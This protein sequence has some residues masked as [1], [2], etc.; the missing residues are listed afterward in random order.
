MH[1]PSVALQTGEWLENQ[2]PIFIGKGDSNLYDQQDG[3]LRNSC[4]NGCGFGQM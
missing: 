3:N 2:T 4:G 1:T